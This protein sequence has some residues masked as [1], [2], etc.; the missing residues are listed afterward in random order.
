[1]LS[2]T[3]QDKATSKVAFWRLFISTVLENPIQNLK[4]LPLGVSPCMAGVG[5]LL[6]AVDQISTTHSKGRLHLLTWLPLSPAS[7]NYFNALST[8]PLLSLPLITLATLMLLT[9]K[10]HGLD[11]IAYWVGYGP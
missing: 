2:R 8:W 7:L 5:N 10:L 9:A 1:M 4:L 3:E 11:E 6:G